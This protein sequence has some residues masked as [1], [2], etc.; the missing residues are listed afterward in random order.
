[1]LIKQGNLTSPRNLVL[2]TLGDLLKNKSAIPTVY[3][4][5]FL[6]TTTDKVNLF[7]K[8]SLLILKALRSL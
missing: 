8:T 5:V 3:C 2:A 1:M 4:I 6:G 7:A